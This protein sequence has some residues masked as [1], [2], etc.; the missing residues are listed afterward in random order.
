[1]FRLGNINYSL[2][3]SIELKREKER[4][5]EREK[6]TFASRSIENKNSSIGYVPLSEKHVHVFVSSGHIQY[7]K[8]VVVHFVEFEVKQMNVVG[9]YFEDQ[10]ET[11]HTRSLNMYVVLCP[12]ISSSFSCSPIKDIVIY[13]LN[14]V[15]KT[16]NP[17][18]LFRCQSM[19]MLCFFH[20]PFHY[21]NRWTWIFTRSINILAWR[22]CQTFCLTMIGH[23]QRSWNIWRAMYRIIQ[24][25]CNDEN[26][27][28]HHYSCVSWDNV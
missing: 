17:F 12:S 14:Q 19:N 15:E 24:Y 5:R 6:L 1:M 27:S 28:M 3:L 4:E 20:V 23:W 8:L 22:I 2:R 26:V 13:H 10:N 7:K 11:N 16:I 21:V 25:V 9:L 18:G